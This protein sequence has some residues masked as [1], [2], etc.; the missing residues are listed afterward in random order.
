MNSTHVSLK[1]QVYKVQ[2][3]YGNFFKRFLQQQQKSE[4]VQQKKIMLD[5]KFRRRKNNSKECRNKQLN[6]T[7]V[8]NLLA[9][10]H[11]CSQKMLNCIELRG[12]KR[13]NLN[14]IPYFNFNKITTHFVIQFI[15]TNSKILF[16]CLQQYNLMAAFCKT[17]LSNAWVFPKI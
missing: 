2:I 14:L 9:L 7:L 15:R 13:K 11:I 3:L 16:S 4:I 8:N 5:L 17:I 1:C 10:K 12:K 6:I